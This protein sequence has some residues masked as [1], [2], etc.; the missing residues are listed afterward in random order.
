MEMEQNNCN[1]QSKP[2]VWCSA[3]VEVGS[4]SAMG[5][6]R[7]ITALSSNTCDSGNSKEGSIYA[8]TPCHTLQKMT[9]N[10][11]DNRKLQQRLAVREAYRARALKAKPWN[12]YLNGSTFKANSLLCTEQFSN[13]I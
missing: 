9:L 5:L 1:F 10:V 6:I 4:K 7:S 3:W 13:L 8:P 11:S 12:H 2:S